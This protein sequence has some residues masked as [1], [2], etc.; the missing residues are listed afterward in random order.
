MAAPKLKVTQVRSEI[1]RMERQRRV[2]RG[3][4]LRGPSSAVIVDNTPSFR[5]MIKKVLHLVSVE[6]TTETTLKKRPTLKKPTVIG[7]PRPKQKGGGVK[8]EEAS[9]T[10]PGLGR[11]K[12]KA[13]AKKAAP[14][15]PPTKKA[16]AAKATTKKATTKKTTT[17]KKAPPPVPKAKKK[18]E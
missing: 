16:T 15:P 18:D 12:E 8:P 10:P 2:L 9:G 13:P 14:K 6:E 4:G 3:L 7:K 11:V 17:K 5:G 1:G